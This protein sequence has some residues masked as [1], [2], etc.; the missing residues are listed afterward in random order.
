MDYLLL[1]YRNTFKTLNE[2]NQTELRLGGLR[3][4]PV[5]NISSAMTYINNLKIRKVQGGEEQQ[6]K[7]LPKN[8]LISYLSWSP[9]EKKIAFTNTTDKGVELW[10]IDVASARAKN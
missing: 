6:V 10:I 7:D 2:L 4:N 1:S 3:I 5:T 9:D 8:P